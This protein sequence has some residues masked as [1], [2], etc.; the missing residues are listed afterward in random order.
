MN[1]LIYFDAKCRVICRKINEGK[2]WTFGEESVMS[3]YKQMTPSAWTPLMMHPSVTARDEDLSCSYKY[4][5][6]EIILSVL[7]H[8]A[9]MSS[10]PSV[11]PILL[12]PT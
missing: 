3:V 5:L 7:K 4:N 12:L 2:V 9:D 8:N 6:S 1:G 10:K 11:L